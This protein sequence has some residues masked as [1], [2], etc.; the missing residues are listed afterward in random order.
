MRDLPGVPAKQSD[1]IT[2]G[3]IYQNIIHK[4]E[5]GII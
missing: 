5:Q 3:K 1:N 4:K 2:T